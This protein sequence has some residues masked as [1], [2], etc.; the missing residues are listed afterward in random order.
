MERRR[1]AVHYRTVQNGRNHRPASATGKSA[2]QQAE[3]NSKKSQ[4]NRMRTVVGSVL[5]GEPPGMAPGAPQSQQPQT[6][7]PQSH[8][9]P[10]T[11]PPAAAPA[12]KSSPSATTPQ[13]PEKVPPA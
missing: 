3:G 11:R 5:L 4:R 8:P 13:E 12:A 7:S 6:S 10:Q 9:H 2:L 1:D